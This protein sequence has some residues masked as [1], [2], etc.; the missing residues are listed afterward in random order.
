MKG[1]KDSQRTSA[2]SRWT[3]SSPVIQ[4]FDSRAFPLQSD[5]DFIKRDRRSLQPRI[6]SKKSP[7]RLC[8]QKTMRWL[9]VDITQGVNSGRRAEK[10]CRSVTSYA[11]AEAWP[12]TT[13]W[14][15][16]HKAFFGRFWFGS[17]GRSEQT[18]IFRVVEGQEAT[19]LGCR[20]FDALGSGLLARRFDNFYSSRRSIELT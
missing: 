13:S 12:G 9:A 3:Q 4:P 8:N 19:Q 20:P 2:A 18:A 15:F 6:H 17:V 11:T 5:E 1:I 16:F 14:G 10:I 7:C